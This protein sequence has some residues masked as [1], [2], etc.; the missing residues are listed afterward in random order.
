MSDTN[1]VFGA[2]WHFTVFKQDLKLCSE[3]KIAKVKIILSLIK[4]VAN[5][6]CF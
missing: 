3:N 5:K 4:I 6:L 1:D 2:H